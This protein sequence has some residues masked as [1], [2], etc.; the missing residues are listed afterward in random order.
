MSACCEVLAVTAGGGRRSCESDI[1]FGACLYLQHIS[2]HMTV[3]PGVLQ[4]PI[5]PLEVE[6]PCVATKTCAKHWLS[7]T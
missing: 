1:K 5:K 2:E 7:M 6:V 3:A 4:L